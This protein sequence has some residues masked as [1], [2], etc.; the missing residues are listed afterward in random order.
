[1]ICREFPIYW[2]KNT[3]NISA[4]YSFYWIGKSKTHILKL[5]WAYGIWFFFRTSQCLPSANL[6]LYKIDCDIS[7]IQLTEYLLYLFLVGTKQHWAM[8][9]K[10]LTQR[11]NGWPLMGFKLWSLTNSDYLM[12]QDFFPDFEGSPNW[13]ILG[14][15]KPNFF[16]KLKNSPP[17]GITAL[18]GLL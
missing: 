3:Y 14:K 4:F 11:N 16:L 12:P 2:S 18:K 6:C 1:M 10:F 7:F 17:S 15:F 8:K 9:I 13:F 5:L